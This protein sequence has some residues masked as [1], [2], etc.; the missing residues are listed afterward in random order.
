MIE[1][2][3]QKIITMENRFLEP[4]IARFCINA[5]MK[6][7]EGYDKQSVYTDSLTKISNY[8]I[9]RTRKDIIPVSDITA[10]LEQVEGIDSVKV[11][12]DADVDNALVYGVSDYYG[13]DEYGDV[14]L[15]RTYTNQTGNTR[16]VRDIL[17]LFRGGFVSP[18]GTE[19]SENQSVEHLSAFNLS[20]SSYTQNTKLSMTNPI[21]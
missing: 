3:G 19:Y 18:S 4:K 21:N 7:W 11:W 15:T 20:V 14:V 1:N 16:Q 2:S 8:L 17:P 12:F 5:S 10:I 6:I 9:N 13:I